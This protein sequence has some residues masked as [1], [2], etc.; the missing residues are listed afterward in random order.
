MGWKFWEK[1]PAQQ[2]A[3]PSEWA[4]DS[5]GAVQMLAAL[6]VGRGLPPFHDWRAPDTDLA[7]DVLPIAEIGAKG[8]QLALWF[9]KFRETHGDIA[10]RMARDAYCVLLDNAGDGDGGAQTE[11]LLT[12]IDEVRASF[13][14]LPEEKRQYTVDGKT[15]DLPFHWFLALAFLTRVSDSPYNDKDDMG[16]ADWD[17]AA[18]LLHASQATPQIWEPMLHRIGPFNPASFPAWKWST[19]PGSLERHLQRRYNNPL[20]TPERRVVTAV[21]VYYARVRDAQALG[22]VRRGLTAVWDELEKGDL[23]INWH[24]FLNDM[25]KQLD[26]LHEQLQRAGGDKELEVLWQHMRDHI[27][28]TWRVA[29]G[30]NPSAIESLEQAEELVKQGRDERCPW[31]HQVSGEGK[32]IPED[33]VTASL[34]SESVEDIRKAAARLGHDSEAMAGLRKEALRLVMRALAEGHQVPDHRRK[35]AVLDVTI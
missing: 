32:T 16:G 26:E 24:P 11:V 21:D 28:K 1:K 15:V 14:N 7:P 34:L 3:A 33:E 27:I 13:E 4:T 31:I 20:F 8:L 25:R 6:Y 30:D 5:Y 9:W 12:I 35:L 18:C 29:V 2:A 17:I 19:H 22:E 23:P 10:M